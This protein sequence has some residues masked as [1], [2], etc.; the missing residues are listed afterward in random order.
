MRLGALDGTGVPQEDLEKL[1]AVLSAV[2]VWG[3]LLQSWAF[4]YKG[5]VKELF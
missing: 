2:S 4:A 1:A 5:C 3:E